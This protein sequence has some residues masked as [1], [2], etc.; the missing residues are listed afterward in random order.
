M[1]RNYNYS[2]VFNKLSRYSH[3]LMEHRRYVIVHYYHI[4]G[5]LFV[6]GYLGRMLR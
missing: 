3:I 4:G 5:Y 1:Q 6:D 2:F